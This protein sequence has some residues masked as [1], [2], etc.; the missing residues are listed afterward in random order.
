MSS[1]IINVNRWQNKL[2]ALFGIRGDN[3]IP[4]IEDLRPAVIIENDRPEFSY[5]GGELLCWVVQGQGV[6][7]G[8]FSFVGLVNP[9]NSNNLT[10]V[11]QVFSTVEALVFIA[12]PSDM[13]AAAPWL[14]G[15]GGSGSTVARD[16]R[17]LR[18][19]GPVAEVP[20]TQYVIGSNVAN[21]WVQAYRIGP[22]ISTVPMQV[23]LPPDTGIILTPIAV[24]LPITA[25]FRFRERPQERG[26]LS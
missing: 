12:G 4:T 10:V 8:S 23:V 7:G 11:D 25:G 17:M 13:G 22:A 24:T 3:P 21:P 2:R 15:A 26:V 1:A 19:I 14:T 20:G 6:V 18:A 16:L 9:P 5:A